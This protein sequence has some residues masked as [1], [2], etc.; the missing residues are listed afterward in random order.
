M[1]SSVE[2][3]LRTQMEWN[4]N[5]KWAKYTYHSKSSCSSQKSGL[6]QIHNRKF[7]D[8]CLSPL[9]L[10]VQ[11]LTA[12]CYIILGKTSFSTGLHKHVDSMC[13][14]GQVQLIQESVV[15]G[16]KLNPRVPCTG[17]WN[18][19]RGSHCAPKTRV[20]QLPPSPPFASLS[21]LPALLLPLHPPLPSLKEK[22]EL[23]LLPY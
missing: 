4:D 8:A 14:V 5:Q 3:Q 1:R 18:Q 12:D 22:N 19:P 11:T 17:A 2:W 6:L 21:T 13:F 15:Q 7:T 9:W 16:K 20:L 10:C 23:Y